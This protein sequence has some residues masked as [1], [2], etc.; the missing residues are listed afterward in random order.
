MSTI[1]D[2]FQQVMDDYTQDTRAA[3]K[4]VQADRDE[5]VAILYPHARTFRLHQADAV[6]DTEKGEKALALLPRTLT[7]VTPDLR[8][9]SRDHLLAGPHPVPSRGM[10]WNPVH[11]ELSF[12][13]S[14][15]E[16]KISGHL[17]MT[18]NRLRAFGTVAVDGQA[19]AVEYRVNPQRY[20]MK[21]A[22]KAAYLAPDKSITWDP[23]SEKW[24]TAEWS[25]DYEVGFTYGI[26]GEEVIGDEKL[27]TFLAKFDDVKSR[28]VWEPIP[29]TY[30]GYLNKQRR[31]NFGLTSG[32]TPPKGPG[33]ELF[34]YRL[35]CT[36]SEFASDF[37][38][39][40]V[41]NPPNVTDPLVYGLI[42]VWTGRGIAGLYH[43]GDSA[44]GAARIVAVHDH[45]LYAGSV[46]AVHTEVDGDVLTWSGLDK[47]VAE[48]AGIPTEGRLTFSPDGERVVESSFGATGVRVHPDA[49]LE[50]G[51]RIS[52]SGLAAALRHAAELAEPD[53]AAEHD[54]T[55]LMGMSQF[56]Q[57]E[58]LEY[59]DKVQE[60]SMEDFYK[61]LQNYMDEDL[62]RTFF[63]KDP[64]PLDAELLAIAGT[65]GTQ[66]TDPY[67][68][69]RS[70]S[71]AYTATCV[72]KFS[73]DPYAKTLNTVRAEQ[74]LSQTTGASDVMAAQS[75]LLYA[76]RWKE[77]PANKNIGWYLA[78][79]KANHAK[80]APEI[81]ATTEVW[82]KEARE[83]NV[84]T[85]EQLAELEKSIRAIGEHAKKH[86]LFW[87][88]AV[89]VGASRPSYML[90]LEAFIK[91]GGEVDGSEFSQRVQRTVAVLNVLDT[92][93]FIS[94]EYS[95]M[96]QLFEL[97][98][99][100]PQMA[101]LDSGIGGFQFALKAILDA[102]W[103]K[104]LDS[105]DPV[106][107][108]AARL[109]KEHASE[110]VVG[111][112]LA[113]LRTTAAVGYG[114]F[115]WGYL[116]AQYQSACS[117]LLAGVPALVIRMGALAAMGTLM[118][119][120]LDGTADWDSLPDT[121]K[122][123]IIVAGINILALNVVALVKRGVALHEVWNPAKGFWKN[124]KM[125]FSSKLLTKAQRTATN[126][127]RGYLLQ[128]GGP[129]V[130]AGRL[131]FKQWWANRQA[132]AAQPLIP[133]P[134]KSFARRLFGKNLTRFMARALAGAFAIVGIVMSSIDLHHS[135]EPL[136]KAANAMFLL[137]ACLEL[138]AVIGSW[139]VAGSA[140][141]VGGLLVSSIFSFV[142]VLGFVA[143]VAGAILLIVLMTRPVQSPVE[144]F[145]KDRAGD[146][147]MPYKAAI[148]TFRIYKPIGEPQRA[149]IAV[150]ATA[151]QSHALHVASD[152][153]VTQAKF[154]ATGHTAFYISV[155]Q[156]GR[157]QI[158]API[159]DTAGKPC[160]LSLAVDDAGAVSAKDYASETPEPEPKLLWFADIQGEGTY[161]ES[162]PGVKDLK[163]APFKLRSVFF[164]DKKET[165]WLATDGAS[166]WRT[167]TDEAEAAT[168]RLEM[169]ATKPTEL[170]MSDV[171]WFTV[172][173]DEVT[174]PGLQV[175]GSV[176]QEWTISPA[177]PEGLEFDKVEGTISM[178]TGID[179]PPAP[180]REYALS[181]KNEIGSAETTFTLEVVLPPEEPP[182]ETVSAGAEPAE[183]P[184]SEMVSAI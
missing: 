3:R 131:T 30:A 8:D 172:A 96:L 109:L 111:K 57:N 67:P 149:G 140:L 120:F 183:E 66:G 31:I 121:Q 11:R 7:L 63:H 69:F 170:A 32:Y 135:K 151:D 5:Q 34:P 162:A 15:G 19:V 168:V 175:P 105:E 107:K 73:D 112:M 138:I 44:R 64:P 97:S 136:E 26:N 41:V 4:A 115:N 108:E 62:R 28:R 35:S 134:A 71:V 92:T 6:S 18:H 85:E 139:A 114:L 55:E 16:H 147:Y 70:L 102:F 88:F 58:K 90:M 159:V 10:T 127:L 81:D 46:A 104:Y 84:G 180:K 43:L 142:A 184:R 174:G 129:K 12:V 1:H 76:N 167:T 51:S 100:L 14:D 13:T 94:Q 95:Y 103:K 146:L 182:S 20:K 116:M 155:N 101:D 117:R 56:T 61:I 27:Y 25:T 150:F 79:Q 173:H 128:E 74:W 181:V 68:W 42:G 144:K 177:L 59:Y 54:L 45:Q 82:I 145:A 156:F 161:Q 39:G 160:L 169:V 77:L 133:K 29:L 40:M 171:S 152:G 89:Y 93:S 78:D 36:L 98:T 110:D 87:A 80:Y 154:D 122:G 38:G 2:E 37:T 22:K 166:G 119:F 158:G 123:F 48:E 164:V 126:G 52:V 65:K 106:L 33:T 124:A 9:P 17:S 47:A 176:P 163:S 50:L 86:K 99:L 21:V 130:P 60:D 53:P 141:A 113:I 165:R 137:A 143:L 132:A 72:G 157:A 49:A 179:I 24:K 178:K 83:N 75:P 23:N 125:F 148:E 118:S 91:L 153:K